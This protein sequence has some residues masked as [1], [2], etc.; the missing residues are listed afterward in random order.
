MTPGLVRAA[1]RKARAAF[2]RGDEAGARA[3][4]A[5]AVRSDPNAAWRLDLAV[6]RA[7]ARGDA[8]AVVARLDRL[9][10]S[11]GSLPEA[12]LRAVRGE[13]L[14]LPA[15]ARNTEALA[16]LA[17]AARLEPGSSWISAYLGRALFHSGRRAA[18]LVA[19]E[20][21]ARLDPACGWVR[22]WQGEALRAS[23]RPRPALGRFDA[24][25]LLDPAYVWTYVWRAGA[26][27]AVGRPREALKDLERFL[28]AEKNYPWAWRAL[29]EAYRRLGDAARAD[30]VLRRSAR[31]DLGA[32]PGGGRVSAFDRRQAAEAAR[33]FGRLGSWAWQGEAFLRLGKYASAEAALTRALEIRPSD[34]WALAWRAEALLALGRIAEACADAEAAVRL[35]PAFP[36]AWAIKGLLQRRAGDA[37]AAA[38][39]FA[40]AAGPGTSASWLHAWHGEALLAAGEP[41][42]ALSALSRAQELDGNFADAW[43]WSGEALRRLGRLAEARAAYDRALSVSPNHRLARLGRGLAAIGSRDFDVSARDLAAAGE[44]LR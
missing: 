28:A 38:R 8:R 18:G 29:A 15:L 44:A 31:R 6:D 23:G 13:G 1:A 33:D 19:L 24:A 37:K 27:L 21:A 11:K 25:A 4:L 35:D 41:R 7:S 40:R 16:E 34:A 17:R 12:W 43:A 32:A 2:A 9:L 39:S 3:A 20:R 42:R 5:P 14:R 10:S 26:R 36:R 30:A 22:A